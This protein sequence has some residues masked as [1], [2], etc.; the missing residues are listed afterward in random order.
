MT[1]WYDKIITIS[2][3]AFFWNAQCEYVRYRRILQQDKARI[4]KKYNAY[5]K[6]AAPKPGFPGTGEP[7][8]GVNPGFSR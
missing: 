5:K 3:A 7:L 6:A 1:G 2:V 4:S 8:T